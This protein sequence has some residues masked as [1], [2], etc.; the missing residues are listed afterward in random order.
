MAFASSVESSCTFAKSCSP[1]SRTTTWEPSI[2]ANAQPSLVA[3]TRVAGDMTTPGKQEGSWR[4]Q[5]LE[6]RSRIATADPH[7]WVL[8]RGTCIVHECR[9]GTIEFDAENPRLRW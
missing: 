3:I 9:S 6:H 8:W 7:V 4:Y 5:G 2:W 1:S